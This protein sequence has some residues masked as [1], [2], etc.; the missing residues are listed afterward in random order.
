MNMISSNLDI[1]GNLTAIPSA[2]D[3]KAEAEHLR[4][5]HPRVYF[6]PANIEV[7]SLAMSLKPQASLEKCPRAKT[8]G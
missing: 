3:A 1:L 6:H 2:G 4:V 5:T 7:A 8:D